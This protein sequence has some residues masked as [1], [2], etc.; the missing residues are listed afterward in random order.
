MPDKTPEQIALERIQ[1]AEQDNRKKLDLSKIKLRT[2]PPEIGKLAN[3][4]D[5]DL[6]GNQLTELPPEIGN[7]DNLNRL[8]L[9]FNH[10]TKPP[11]QSSHQTSS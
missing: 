8:D 9:Q 10:L 7:L 5:I 11:L 6:S 4:I 1:E 2:L 3:L